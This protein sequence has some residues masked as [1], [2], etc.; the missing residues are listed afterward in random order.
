MS[1]CLPAFTVC[2]EKKEYVKEEVRDIFDKGRKILAEAAKKLHEA[3]DALDAQIPNLVKFLESAKAVYK[4]D[5]NML[6]NIEAA[7]L[8]LRRLDVTLDGVQ[9]LVDAA[10][11]TQITGN[12]AQSSANL[13]ISAKTASST[14]KTY[15]D[16]LKALDVNVG[17]A[18]A[19]LDTIDQTLG[20]ITALATLVGLNTNVATTAAA[21][22]TAPAAVPAEAA[23]APTPAP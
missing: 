19:V 20:K 9:D 21:V 15:I 18:P 14:F 6:A 16:A 17:I 11:A 10:Q 4:D 22:E 1:G 8:F 13:I 3:S 5:A 23:P 2:R 12:V 7:I